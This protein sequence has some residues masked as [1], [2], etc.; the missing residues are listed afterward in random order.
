MMDQ[1]R[2]NFQ[3]LLIGFRSCS[4]ALFFVYLNLSFDP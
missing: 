4:P 1:G 2:I 3:N